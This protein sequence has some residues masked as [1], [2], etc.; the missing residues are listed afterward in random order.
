[1]S[2][3]SGTSLGHLIT[4][5]ACVL[6]YIGHLDYGSNIWHGVRDAFYIYIY[7]YFMWAISHIH[8]VN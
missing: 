4:F 6:L 8:V 3:Q 5:S 2:R 1:M 7:F